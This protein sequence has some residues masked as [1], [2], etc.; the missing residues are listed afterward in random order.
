MSEAFITMVAALRD[1]QRQ[2]EQKP[3]RGGQA[4]C[5]IL[6]EKV[7]AWLERHVVEMAQL[8]FWTRSV[9]SSELPGA[10]NV[11]D[12]TEAKNGGAA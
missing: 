2:Q 11:T 8:D 4:E 7:D 9:K 5:N 1:A 6:A 12:E 3:T 10:Y